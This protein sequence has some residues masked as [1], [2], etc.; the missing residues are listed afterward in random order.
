[1]GVMPR[2]ARID[3][4][5]ALHRIII[6]GIERRR[7]IKDDQDRDNFIKRQWVDAERCFIVDK[8][9]DMAIEVPLNFNRLLNITINLS[10]SNGRRGRR[11]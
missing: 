3:A 1:M 10:H 6:R 11:P 2:K 8:L 4:P 9:Q 5:G 7:I